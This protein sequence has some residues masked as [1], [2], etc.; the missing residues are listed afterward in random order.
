VKK[1][2]ICTYKH[3]LCSECN[4]AWHGDSNCEED[5]EI[6]DF[7]R[8]SGIIPKKCPNCKVWTE[9]NLGC[10]HMKC[11]ICSYNW[12]WLCSQECPEDHYL[13]PGP[14]QG[15][16]FDEGEIN[17]MQENVLIAR[18]LY[19]YRNNPLIYYIVFPLLLFFTFNNMIHTL[20]SPQYQRNRRNR[21]D[22]NL[23][24]N[25]N[26]RNPNV[27]INLGNPSEVNNGNEVKKEIIDSQLNIQNNNNNFNNNANNQGEP[28][29]ANNN[30]LLNNDLE[31]NNYINQNNDNN[32]HMELGCCEKFCTKILLIFSITMM[33]IIFMIIFVT[34]NMF[35]MMPITMLLGR[36]ER[37][38]NGFVKCLAL[39]T[40]MIYFL[41]SYPLGAGI[42]V[43][44]F[45]VLYVLCILKIII[46]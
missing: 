9:K 28:V 43:V 24:N 29:N 42:T 17:N 39:G 25:Q 26:Q 45:G 41:I 37:N 34:F 23:L 1:K 8:F 38:A 3:E 18:L 19:T 27:N 32:D 2:L 4:Q 33:S 5:K 13:N 40:Y 46:Y 14:C 36:F 12:C 21:R 22:D 10:N 16:Q 44:Y 11:K 7:A 15:K 6:K 20:L 31:M 30:L 35:N